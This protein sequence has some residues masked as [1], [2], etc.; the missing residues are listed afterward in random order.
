MYRFGR[1]RFPAA[2]ADARDPRSFQPYGNS[3]DSK[4]ID[5]RFFLIFFF[6]LPTDA[7]EHRRR[8]RWDEYFQF[9]FTPH[10]SVARTRLRTE[11]RRLFLGRS[12][13]VARNSTVIYS[14]PFIRP[15]GQ[16]IFR[17]DDTIAPATETISVV[18]LRGQFVSRRCP[19]VSVYTD[20]TQ[21]NAQDRSTSEQP[22]V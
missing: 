6:L 5:E 15:F 14:S 2:M 13:T 8:I 21:P 22:L 4:M 3:Q 12:I 10:A 19:R 17:P 9:C 11:P 7:R 16:A 1:A 18:Y 20:C